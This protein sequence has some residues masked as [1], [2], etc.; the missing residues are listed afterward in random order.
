MPALRKR[1]T[2]LAGQL[3]ALASELH[4]AETYLKLA[5]T[6]DGLRARIHQ[7]ADQLTV[8]DRQRVLRL[9]VREVRIGRD[10]VTIRHSIP[11]PTSRSDPSCLLRGRSQR[12]PLR[13][14]FLARVHQPVGH[15]AR[16]QVAPD[17]L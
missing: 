3:E 17:Q 8:E 6:L 9:V 15:D 10:D 14:S 4:D 2:T 12:R 13:S 1:E 16:F 5:D 11:A 7:T